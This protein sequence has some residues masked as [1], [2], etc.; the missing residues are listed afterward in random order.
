MVRY[1]RQLL[2]PEVGGLGQSRFKRAR[3]LLV[4]V[5]GLGSP[6]ALYLAG[7][8]VGTVGLLDNDRVDLSNLPRQILHGTSSIGDLKVESGRRRLADLNPD[9]RVNL[10]AN[11]L[12]PTNASA[13][14]GGYDIVVDGSDNFETRYLVNQATVRAG[15]PLVWGAVLRWEGQ[16]M[17]VLPGR[18]AC[19]A[20]L[21]PEPPIS[22]P[23]C[24]EAGIL[25]PVAGL[26][27]SILAAETLKVLLKSGDTLAGRFLQVDLRTMRFRERPVARR[28]DCAACGGS[29]NRR[30]GRASVDK[31]TLNSFNHGSR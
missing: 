8:G 10:H 14:I 7:A 16:L 30:Q 23:S 26:V 22:A 11:R 29:L 15:K 21:F 2:V 13:L 1:S 5:G 12:N 9:I 3:V 28:P 18:S 25:G 19:Y 6:A 20:C 27:G 31:G 24:S 17:T 4:G